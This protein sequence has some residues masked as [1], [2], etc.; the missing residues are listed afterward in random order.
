MWNPFDPPQAT[1]ENNPDADWRAY[2]IPQSD[3]RPIQVA[4]QVSAMYYGVVRKGYEHPEAAIR[5]LNLFT[6]KMWGETADNNLGNGDGS[7]YVP[8]KY[9][10]LQVWPALKNVNGHKHVVAALNAKDPSGLN[11]EERGY[12]EN[13]VKYLNDG[14]IKAG[15]A[16]KIFGA[17]GSLSV[18]TQYIESNAILIDAYHNSPTPTMIEKMAT[19]DKLETEVFTKIIMGAPLEEFDTFAQT[20]KN[21]AGIRSRKK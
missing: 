2:P 1:V 12:Y 19:L 11:V 14:D 8:F 3:T 18:I 7:T 9:S 4:T 21:S 5:M 20:G 16:N 17:D 13:I 10:L 6:E 15:W